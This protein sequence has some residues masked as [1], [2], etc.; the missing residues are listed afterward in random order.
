MCFKKQNHA[1]LMASQALKEATL[2]RGSE[3][4][5]LGPLHPAGAPT[6]TKSGVAEG[7]LSSVPGLLGEPGDPAFRDHSCTFTTLE[8]HGTH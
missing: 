4:S 8:P 3:L 6:P 2:S 1:T 7:V 5:P